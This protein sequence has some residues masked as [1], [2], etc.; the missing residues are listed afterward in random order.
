MANFVD[1]NGLSA[2]LAFIKKYIYDNSD[3]VPA[4]NTSQYYRGDKTWQT[5]NSTAVGLGNVNNTADANKPVSTAMQN[6]LNG[7]Q[8]TLVSG[9][10]IR[11]INGDTILGGGGL[12]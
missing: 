3:V 6:A 11:T 12:I 4:G 5:L 10:N 7:K 2:A 1:Q 9:T 8:N